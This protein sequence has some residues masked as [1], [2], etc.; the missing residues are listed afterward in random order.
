MESVL[1]VE[2]EL[3]TPNK[4]FDH[5][6]HFI[7]LLDRVLLLIE[8]LWRRRTMDDLVRQRLSCT[9]RALGQL[10]DELEISQIVRV[11]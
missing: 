4:A 8:R 6:Y 2:H 7:A 9:H 10:R 5:R 11:A 1:A 3:K